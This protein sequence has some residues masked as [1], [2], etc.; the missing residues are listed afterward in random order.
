MG[1]VGPNDIL[2]T[3]GAIESALARAGYKFEIGAGVA[4]AQKSLI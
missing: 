3:V 2:A 4:A 1:A